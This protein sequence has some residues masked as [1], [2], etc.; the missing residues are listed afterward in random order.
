MGVTIVSKNAIFR[1]ALARTCSERGF[2]VSGIWDHLSDLSRV[3]IR[4]V[5]LLHLTEDFDEM[6]AK[7]ADLTRANTGL[8]IILLVPSRKLDEIAAGCADLVTAVIPDIESADTLFSVLCLAQLG[9]KTS[10]PRKPS[11][12]AIPAATVAR[13]APR[14]APVEA[15]QR[16]CSSL[17]KREAAIL[18]HLCSGGSNKSI[19]NALRISDATV[20]VH[21]RMA[22]RKI[23]V[24]NRTQAALWATQ[25]L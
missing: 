11:T 3:D 18:A 9:Y 24:S 14:A 2:W 1:E 12:S 13:E 10:C 5:V 7:I 15:E 16:Q 8:R 20:K 21:L 4:D 17:S 19:A 25:N 22:F 6:S 23:G